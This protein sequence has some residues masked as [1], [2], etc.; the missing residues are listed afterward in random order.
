ML[1]Q[2]NFF[3]NQPS[4]LPEKALAKFYLSTTFG[5]SFMI[6]YVAPARSSTFYAYL[7]TKIGNRNLK[8]F[9]VYRLQTGFTWSE[10]GNMRPDLLVRLKFA[11]D[12]SIF[13]GTHWVTRLVN[14]LSMASLFSKG[15]EKNNFLQMFK[16]VRNL[17]THFE[18]V[19]T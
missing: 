13:L 1:K 15:F 3:Y 16:V 14:V 4:T 6:S 18:H 11:S 10:P 8:W 19:K 5:L 7:I 17:E 12:G 2:P 9:L